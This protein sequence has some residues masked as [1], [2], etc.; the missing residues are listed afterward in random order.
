MK[1][2]ALHLA[3]FKCNKKMIEILLEHNA[4]ELIQD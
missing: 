1:G 4:N 2:S 3:A